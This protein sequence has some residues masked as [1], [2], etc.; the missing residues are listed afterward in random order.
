MPEDGVSPMFLV[1]GVNIPDNLKLHINTVAGL[2]YLLSF[3]EQ[4][5]LVG[6]LLP[7]SID[8]Y[9]QV[10]PLFVASVAVVDEDGVNN[11]CV[12]CPPDGTFQE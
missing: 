7:T 1:S 3:L 10:T 12:L 11:I 6:I 4:E 8:R 2:V 5:Q 9:K